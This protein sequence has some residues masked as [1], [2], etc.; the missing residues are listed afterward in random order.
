[1]SEDRQSQTTSGRL[2]FTLRAVVTVALLGLAATFVDLNAIS[3]IVADVAWPW[4]AV[5]L[6]LIGVI[7]VFESIQFAAVTRAFG[8]DLRTL[9]S[10]RMTL[11]GRFFAL[12]T[13]AMLGSDVY[14]AVAMQRLGRGVRTSV[15]LAAISR[16]MSLLALVP[17]LVAGLP[18]V[19]YYSWPTM[20]FW[21]FAAIVVLTV[22]VCLLLLLVRWETHSGARLSRLRFLQELS[23]EASKLRFVALQSPNKTTL[24]IAAVLQHVIRVGAIMA[25]ARAFGIEAGWTVFF[26]F[27]PVSLLIAM[28]PVSVGSWGLRELAL[29]FSLGAAGVPAGSALLTSITF[30]L[31]GM[32]FALLGGLIWMTGAGT[33]ISPD[34]EDY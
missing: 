17:V 23:L 15:S 27:V 10:L 6:S 9:N 12:V 8:Y 30:G 5:G 22:V 18:F 33:Q 14:R 29:V 16:I 31:L 34:P 32:S 26:A 1:M 7:I 11:V 24:W 13:P 21:V 2:K 28:I 20:R 4:L 25:V 3:D 19:A